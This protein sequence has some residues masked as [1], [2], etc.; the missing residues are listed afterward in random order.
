M[1]PREVWGRLGAWTR[2]GRLER[3]LS[4]ELERHLELM[5]RDLEAE[6]MNAVEA[7]AEAR[8]RLGGWGDSIC[9]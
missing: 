5:A 4:N 3:Q 1:N 7:R 9:S 8:R 6:G 2:R